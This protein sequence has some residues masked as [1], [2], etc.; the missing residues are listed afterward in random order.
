MNHME[1]CTMNV[2]SG[3][4]VYLSVFFICHIKNDFMG[5]SVCSTALAYRFDMS[6][7]SRCHST[8]I[9]NTIIF[10]RVDV[11]LE[12]S[13]NSAKNA[14]NEHRQKTKAFCNVM[15]CNCRIESA[16][17]YNVCTKNRVM[18]NC[19]KSRPFELV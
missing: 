19:E 11:R 2:W 7:L 14:D 17:I 6:S 12:N 18:N 8:N 1:K 5:M 3:V 13:C 15:H 9:F 10:G 16:P 4:S